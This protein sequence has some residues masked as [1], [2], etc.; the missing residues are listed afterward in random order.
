[1]SNVDDNGYWQVLYDNHCSELPNAEA[2]LQVLSDD[3]F[4]GYEQ[5]GYCNQRVRQAVSVDS[6]GYL[7]P[8]VNNDAEVHTLP[9][10]S[11]NSS[12]VIA[13]DSEISN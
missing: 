13:A 1:M 2:Y 10:A 5:A 7:Q 11:L 9:S 12:D 3:D 6:H 8:I 4:A